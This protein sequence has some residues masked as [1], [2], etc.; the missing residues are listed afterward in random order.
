M[1]VSISRDHMQFL[2]NTLAEIAAHKAG[3]IKPGTAVVSARQEPEA[4][5]VIRETAA[6]QRAK[7]CIA[8]VAKATDV[9]CGL[10]RQ[11]FS[12]GGYKDL[13]IHLAGTCQ[14][15]NAVVA[16]E[17]VRALNS[18]GFKITEGQLRAGLSKT[19]WRG[20]FTVLNEKPLFII[21]G[22]HN[23][24]AAEQLKASIETYLKG[25]RII[26][27]CGVL[28]DKEYEAVLKTV[29]PYIKEMITIETPDNPRALPAEKLAEIAGKY[30]PEVHA[31]GSIAEAAAESI[32]KAEREDGVILAFGSLSFLGALAGEAEKVTANGVNSNK[33]NCGGEMPVRCRG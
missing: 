23:R 31:A 17:A 22:A 15:E 8:D 1:L 9:S 26:A 5:Q 13:E 27:I 32:A 33:I 14:I 20:R 12:Y 6:Q 24:G 10:W 28:R 30:I 7:L 4:M 19:V 16:V 3:I 11:S 25:R 21:D 18:L 29:A 2:G